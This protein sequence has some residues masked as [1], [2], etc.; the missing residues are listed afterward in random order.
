MDGW[1]SFYRFA[2]LLAP[3]KFSAMARLVNKFRP[4]PLSN[5]EPQ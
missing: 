1:L 3:E 5:P 2:L 4:G